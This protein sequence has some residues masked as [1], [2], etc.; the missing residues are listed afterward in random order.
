MKAPLSLMAASVLLGSA[1]APDALADET[2]QSPYMPKITG[3]EE[4]VYIWTLG[5][6]GLGDGSDKLV[7]VDVREDS[8]TFGQVIDTD[9]VGGRHEA[10]HGGLTDD[11][12]QFW[13]GGLDDSM[14]FIFDIR[15]DP[16][17]PRLVKTID[18]FEEATGGVAGPHGFY[19]LPGRMLI[20]ALTNTDGT[21]ET[22]LVE[23]TNG[24][25]FIATHWIPAPGRATDGVQ[26]AAAADGYGYDARVLP[27]RN[28]MLTSSFTGHDNYMRP[29]GELVNDAEAM[30]NF[31]NTMVLWD[32]HAR[33][34]KKVL[35][36]PGV[37]L[38]IRF[39][40]G[41]NN[42]Y[43]FTSTALTS[44]LWLIHED[45]QG[46]WQAK[47][48]ADI[49]NPDDLPLPVDISLSSDD[50]TLW[51][52]TFLDGMVRAFDVSDPHNPKQIFE[53]KMGTQV[54][55]VSQSWDGD[56]LYFTTSL[57]SQWD[58]LGDEND[59]FLKAFT[60]DGQQLAPRFEIDFIA[61]GLGRPHIMRFGSSALY[62]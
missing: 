49:G 19:A 44:Q 60:W 39:A 13:L 54:N 7:T 6:E 33:T 30:K 11:R 12:S 34:P 8:D 40:W 1:V 5:M 20:S 56:R 58:K 15:S 29:L 43:A 28:V 21:G 25:E 52:D 59:Q 62:Q 45:D 2:C 3:T 55:M 36:V 48:V 4:F 32:L 9:S 46:E 17:N 47:A 10:H 37:P 57:L 22:A 16:A 23:Y 35:E 53:Q 14:I 41:P 18:D 27:R 51:V 50:S 31:G 26:N 42:N 24:G 38:E 61:E